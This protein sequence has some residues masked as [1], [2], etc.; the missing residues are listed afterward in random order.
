MTPNNPGHRSV[1][2]PSARVSK[3]PTALTESDTLF[4]GS[5]VVSLAL[6][7]LA[8]FP[9]NRWLISRGQGHALVHAFHAPAAAPTHSE[10]HH[11]HA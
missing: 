2:S 4:W 3:S 10:H 7:F 1:A 5:L 9:I 8:T 11:E 6:A